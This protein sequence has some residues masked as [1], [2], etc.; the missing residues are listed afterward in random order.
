MAND[1]TALRKSR[2]SRLDAL[3]QEVQ[4]LQGNNNQGGSDD[5]RFWKPEVDKAGNG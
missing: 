4:K 5:D 3:Q 2:Q 1:F